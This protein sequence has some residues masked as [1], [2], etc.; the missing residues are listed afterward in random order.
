M[1]ALHLS[2][3]V[4]D[5]TGFRATCTLHKYCIDCWCETE[6]VDPV[7]TIARQTALL[8]PHLPMHSTVGLGEFVTFPPD[9]N[10]IE[11][12]KWALTQKGF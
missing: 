2:P 3:E 11:T 4:P 6:H 1:P 9:S 10:A 7:D 5:P 8:T 12:W